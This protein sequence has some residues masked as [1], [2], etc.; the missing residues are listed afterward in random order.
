MIGECS[1]NG[2][3]ILFSKAKLCSA[4]ELTEATLVSLSGGQPQTILDWGNKLPLD[5]S[6]KPELKP[7]SCRRQIGDEGQ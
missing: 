2:R 4:L 6:V 7:L 1:S 3:K 5:I